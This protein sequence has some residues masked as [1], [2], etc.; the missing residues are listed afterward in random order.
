MATMPKMKIKVE[1]ADDGGCAVHS[2]YLLGLSVHHKEDGCWLR[3]KA[4]NGREAM[5]DLAAYAKDRGP[6]V[7]SA[8]EQWIED[9]RPNT[10]DHAQ[11]QGG[12]VADAL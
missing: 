8:I 7:R 9:G 5:I 12:S 2:K 4:S 10:S 3:F 11:F 1:R 6:I